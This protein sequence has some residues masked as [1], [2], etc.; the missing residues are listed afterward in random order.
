[1][2]EATPPHVFIAINAIQQELGEIGIGKNKTAEMGKF[3]YNFRGIDDIYAA[4]SP[5]L[6]V[7]GLVITPKILDREVREVETEKTDYKG[8]VSTTHTM[9]T[10]L[11]VQYD[12]IS[13]RDA[14]RHD[15]IVVGEAM[16]SGDKSTNKAM[17]AAYK[18]MALQVFCIPTEGT[19]NDS[20]SETYKMKGSTNTVISAASTGPVKPTAAQNAQLDMEENVIQ[21]AQEHGWPGR[22]IL[23]SSAAKNAKSLTDLYKRLQSGVLKGPGAK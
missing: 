19:N 20:E 5:L 15:C 23:D 1:M 6:A 12:F 22:S 10:F 3:S 18:Y 14:S 4:L 11:T 8:N 21:I 7:H 17:S 13:S 9:Y 2:T 16:D